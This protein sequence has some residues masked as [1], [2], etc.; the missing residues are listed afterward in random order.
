M[1]K[2]L[3]LALYSTLI[4]ASVASIGTA[5]GASWWLYNNSSVELTKLT[6][7]DLTQEIV[8]ESNPVE[9]VTYDGSVEITSAKQLKEY[10][11]DTSQPLY[12]RN[13]LSIPGLGTNLQ[14]YEGISNR[15]LTYGAGTIKPGQSLTSFGNYAIAAHNFQDA[16]WGHGFASLQAQPN[17]IGMQAYVSDGNNVYT[18]TFVDYDNVYRDDSMKFTED[19]WRQQ[20]LQDEI[21][22]IAPKE[23]TQEVTPE[24]IFNEN[25]SY[26]DNKEGKTFTYGKLLTLYTCFLEGYYHDQSWNRIIATA[27]MTKEQKLSEAPQDVQALFL[28]P[29]GNLT[30]TNSEEVPQEAQ[31]AQQSAAATLNADVG[32]KSQPQENAFIKWWNDSVEENPDLPMTVIIAG[33]VVFT[34]SIIGLVVLNRFT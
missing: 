24:R 34:T 8:P 1:N 17:I 22:Q 15:V 21:K 13:Y 25:E 12:L 2:H 6:K 16:Q 7:P 10:R 26:V 31:V 30:V 5:G 11:N 23:L 18:Y 28:D 14:I 29:A 3:K 20:F 33:L 4:L 19:D 27:V 32:L 9:G